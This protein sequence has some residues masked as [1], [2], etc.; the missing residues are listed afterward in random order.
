[1][2]IVGFEPLVITWPHNER[3]LWVDFAKLKAEAGV[4]FPGAFHRFRF[5]DRLMC[6]W[7]E[8]LTLKQCGVD[9]VSQLP[10]MRRADFRRGKRLGKGDHIVR[11]PK[12]FL[13]RSLSWQLNK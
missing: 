12:P 3:L 6:T 8:L 1:M 9:S 13:I 5:T 4:A 2:A 11:W 10:V 7:R